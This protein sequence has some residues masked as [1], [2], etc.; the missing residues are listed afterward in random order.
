MMST[1]QEY[2]EERRQFMQKRELIR[3]HHMLS[4][5]SK[6]SLYFQNTSLIFVV[7]SVFAKP[8][9]RSACPAGITH[10]VCRR[11]LCVLRMRAQGQGALT[12]HLKLPKVSPILQKCGSLIWR[13]A[14]CSLFTVH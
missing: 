14:H 11:S 10:L 3:I 7:R 2:K 12:E 9:G 5:S 6:N 4:K 1:Q 13:P 8:Y